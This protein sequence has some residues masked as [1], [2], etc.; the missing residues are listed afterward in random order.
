M[1]S[2]IDNAIALKLSENGY[3]PK[4]PAIR[5]LAR[6]FS[7]V[8]IV[9]MLIL[10]GRVWAE[11]DVLEIP[12]SYA[13]SK[14]ARSAPKPDAEPVTVDETG[15][16]EATAATEEPSGPPPDLG[17]AR[18]YIDDPGEAAPAPRHA[19]SSGY[20]GGYSR[21]PVS[22]RYSYSQP[23]P[24]SSYSQPSPYS[25]RGYGQNPYAYDPYGYDPYNRPDLYA[26]TPYRSPYP[27]YGYNSRGYGNDP[28]AS[29]IQ[30][31]WTS[32]VIGGLMV[33]IT[34]AEIGGAFQQRRR[35]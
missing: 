7:I 3:R 27:S 20:S 35:R 13:G 23:S 31:D 33:G 14:H 5:F 19:H 6:A 24:Y 10:P 29:G 12:K 2:K 25:S 28:G 9:Q 1:T 32:L 21:P 15:T 22:P 8:L 16:T 26:F 18:D 11:N 30:V 17:S 34:A 4:R